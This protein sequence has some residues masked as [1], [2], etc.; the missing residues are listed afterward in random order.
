[1]PDATFAEKIIGDGIAIEPVDEVL[2]A[3]ADGE[4]TIVM[5]DS[6]HACALKL[7]NGVDILLH[8]GLDTIGMEGNGFECLVNV[9]D[10]VKQGDQLIRFDQKKIK[11]AGY[12]IVTMMVITES[13][14][15]RF[16]W[17]TDIEV[18]AGKTIVAEYS[19]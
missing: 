12:K 5:E 9:G 2:V 7:T 8:I 14:G 4:V 15:F 13:A 3:P 16:N 19:K 1:M 17:K 10:K 11:E 18:E 6:Y